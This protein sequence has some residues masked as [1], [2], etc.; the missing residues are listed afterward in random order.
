MSRSRRRAAIAAL[1]LA[2]FAASG[3]ALAASATGPVA[4][5]PRITCETPGT[6][7]VVHGV[8]P[9]GAS[10]VF[11]AYEDGASIQ[12]SIAHGSYTLLVPS[13]PRAGGLPDEL[14]YT[15]AR[16]ARHDRLLAAG[17]FPRCAPASD[18]AVAPAAA[19]SLPLSGTL[20]PSAANGRSGITYAI[21]LAPAM[22]AGQIGW[23]DSLLTYADGQPEDLGTGSCDDGTAA[24]GSPLFGDP[25]GIGE[26]GLHYVFAAPQVTAVRIAGGPTVRTRTDPT[27]PLGIKAAV[28]TLPA[29]ATPTGPE[30]TALDAAGRRIPGGESQPPPQEPS[31]SWHV[32]HVAPRGS[33]SIAAHRGSGIDPGL[34]SVLSAITPDPAIRGRA[35]LSC[36]NVEFIL[37]GRR[38]GAAVLLD[39]AHPGTPPAD[40]PEVL[41]V[42]GHP[43]M[44]DRPS[45]QSDL[46]N[47]QAN[48]IGFAARR[49]GNAWLVVGGMNTSLAE[50]VSALANLTIGPLDLRPPTGPPATPRGALCTI[51]TRPLP[52]LHEVSQ[53]AITQLPVQRATP[54]LIPTPADQTTLARD[55]RRIVQDAARFPNDHALIARDLARWRRDSAKART[56]ARPIK[57]VAALVQCASASFYYNDWPLTA[58]VWL[59]NGKPG[60][61]WQLQG[62]QPVHGHPGT[63][64]TP[65][66]TDSPAGTWRLAGDDWLAVQGGSGPGQQLTV[67]NA[68]TGAIA[69][70]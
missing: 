21:A 55:R 24:L 51:S 62:K 37:H 59:S 61:P 47:Q 27:L 58:T 52:G 13:V 57:T 20:P 33:C 39:A 6:L 66:Q 45:A 35:F 54:L 32:P 28:F 68:L 8:L 56:H 40:L 15:T 63:F 5:T 42:S 41:P 30:L 29:Q 4:N 23:C 38:F 64:T 11:L 36:A 34:G 48:I 60:T 18:A 7:W 10:A 31:E 43:G 26:A 65:G 69:T 19:M 25:G 46:I 67:L 53:T 1:V 9:R 17:A 3:F 70:K 2:V 12:A 44:V 22:L 14:I 16:G 50:R 49:I